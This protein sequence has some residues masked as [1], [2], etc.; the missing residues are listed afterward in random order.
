MPN[1]HFMRHKHRLSRFSHH[2]FHPGE[3]MPAFPLFVYNRHRPEGRA[4]RPRAALAKAL[5]EMRADPQKKAAF[6]ALACF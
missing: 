1:T 4:V 2:T 5:R 3:T 6:L